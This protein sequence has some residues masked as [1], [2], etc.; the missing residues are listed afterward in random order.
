MQSAGTETSWQLLDF[1]CLHVAVN[2]AWLLWQIIAVAA[3]AL[4]L[5]LSCCELFH[6]TSSLHRVKPMQCRVYIA[7]HIVR[8]VHTGSFADRPT[9]AGKNESSLKVK[10]QIMCPNS[11]A[12][13]SRSCGASTDTTGG[14]HYHGLHRL[15]VNGSFGLLPNGVRSCENC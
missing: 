4:R 2:G 5:P 9:L 1:G 14:D 3:I 12:K 13:T 6:E 7:Q 11:L 10:R 15:F 8:F